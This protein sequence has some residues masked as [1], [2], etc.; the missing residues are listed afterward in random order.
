[1][2]DYHLNKSAKFRKFMIVL[3]FAV[4]KQIESR[5]KVCSK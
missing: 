5:L 1:M 2:E 3:F 4:G